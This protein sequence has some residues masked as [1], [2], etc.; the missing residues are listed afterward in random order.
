MDKIDPLEQLEV[1]RRYLE[2][3]TEQEREGD[4]M[5]TTIREIERKFNNQKTSIR[6][7]QLRLDA[8]R[9]YALTHGTVEILA[10]VD[11][12]PDCFPELR[13]TYGE[14]AENNP[15]RITP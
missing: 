7:Y 11:A 8:I 1:E 2:R 5:D 10:L 4:S 15:D 6:L 3:T 9:R 13:E 12:S 14:A